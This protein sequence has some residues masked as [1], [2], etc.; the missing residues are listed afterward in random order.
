[1]DDVHVHLRC[2]LRLINNQDWEALCDGLA[3]RW[4]LL[5]KLAR[6]KQSIGQS[7]ITS[8]IEAAFLNNDPIALFLG[9]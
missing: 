6:V 9:I 4:I 2:V 8:L 3:N 1:M 5:Y 7:K